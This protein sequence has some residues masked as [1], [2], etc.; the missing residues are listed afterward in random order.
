MTSAEQAPVAIPPV[1]VRERLARATFLM[2]LAAAL[3]WSFVP[4]EI[5][6]LPQLFTYSGNIADYLSGF[7]RPN[8][9]DWR[10][11]ISEMVIT[12][13]I[14]IWGTFLAVLL[15][16]P[17]GLLSSNNIAPAYVVQPVRRLMDAFRA[18]NEFIFAIIFVVAVGLGPFAGVMALFVSTT[19]TLAKLFSE[20]VEA[21]DPRPVEGLSLLH[22]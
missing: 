22:I 12:V 6:K 15:S 7:L 3:A 14:A 2:L 21:I 11:Y 13:Q 4:A 17:F 16:V 20:A 19:G 8:F 5:H 18:I 9:K 10:F 1:P